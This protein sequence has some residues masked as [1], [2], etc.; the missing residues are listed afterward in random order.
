MPDRRPVR[1]LVRV[2]A[3]LLPGR[4]AAEVFLP[5]AHDLRIA[6]LERRGARGGEGG[7]EAAALVVVWLDCLR[8]ALFSGARRG[9]GSRVARAA[10][11]RDGAGVPGR[12]PTRKG[13]MQLL[14]LVPAAIRSLRRN[15]GYAAAGILTLGLAIGA[16]SAV[17][18]VV[19][20][21]LLRPLPFRD[22]ERILY[23]QHPATRAG[24]ADASFSFMEIDDIR[25]AARTVDQV[26][27]YGDW[28]FIV[29]GEGDPHRAVA[30]LVTSNYFDVLGLRATLGR[31]LRAEDDGEGGEPVMVL[32]HGYWRRVFGADPDV[33]GRTVELSGKRARV[34]G[35][36]EPGV[37]Y[38][39][40]REL[41]FYA[42]YATNDHYMGAAMRDSRT[43]RMTNI[44]ARVAEGVTPEAAAQ[45]LEA[46]AARMRERYPEAYPAGMG[47]QVVARP[48]ADELTRQ[49]RPIFLLLMG[50]VS[51]VLLLACANVTNLTLARLIQREHELATR[52]ALGARPRDLRLALLVENLVLAVL[53]AA[54]GLGIAALSRGALVSYASRFTLRAQ[55]VGIDW[56]VVGVTFAAAVAVAVALAW[57]PG[58]VSTSRV[59]SAA[60]RSTQGRARKRM[61]RGLVVAQLALSFALL[62][63]SGLLVRTLLNLL[64]VDPGFRVE[65][66]LTLEAVGGGAG[67]ITPE[68]L[69]TD[70]LETARA[71][72]GVRHAAVAS[73]APLTGRSTIGFDVSVVGRPES[74]PQSITLAFNAVSGEYFDALEMRL[75]EGR[76]FEETDRAG[77]ERVVIL[78]RSMARTLFGDASAIGEQIVISFPGSSNVPP[79]SRVV[80]VVSDTREHGLQTTGAHTVYAPAR[81]ANWGPTVL[82][83]TAGEPTSV[84]KAIADRIHAL[85]PDRPVDRIRT[86]RELRA[87]EVAPTR[88]NATLFGGF[89]LLALLIAAVGVLGV[90]A[91]SV[92]RRTRE[93]GVR[94][95]LGEARGALLRNVLGEGL[96][97]AGVALLAGGGGAFL[98]GRLLAGL[99]YGVEPLDMSTLA[100]AAGLLAAATALAAFFPALRATRVDPIIALKSE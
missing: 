89:A 9:E 59:A 56:R 99:L 72:P 42:N 100:A 27:E 92:G 66:V 25:A 40:T 37:S 45:E 98:L 29:V 32:T 49:A 6:R 46:V 91:F 65:N 73:W 13:P 44:F 78:G 82:V 70:V 63:G 16:N 14:N 43:H 31:P 85:D 2:L 68:A 15:P 76:F 4:L 83:V 69:F 26:V 17:F 61:Q 84:I 60:A 12:F 34:V 41:D 97:M 79:P 53:G 64:A 86:M 51:A 81:Q 33:L 71:L 5:A 55:E 58:A 19:N 21:V 93:F 48:W 57:L 77:A 10:A 20:G 39:G 22:A 35:V 50:T 7:G 90:M 67:A 24:L 11:A 18:S 74:A 52:G 38:T 88:L 80:G 36:L 54:V 23:V 1:R 30:G 94:M 8:L 47:L 28:D 95:A 96:A 62:A 75:V 3:A 87:A